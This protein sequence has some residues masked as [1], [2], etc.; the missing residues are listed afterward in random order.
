VVV[1]EWAIRKQEG[2]SSCALG[3]SSPLEFIY[4]MEI[5]WTSLVVQW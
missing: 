3:Y 1:G 2:A 4:D 5:N